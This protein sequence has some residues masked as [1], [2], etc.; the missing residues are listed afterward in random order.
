MASSHSASVGLASRTKVVKM[1]DERSHDALE[2]RV[3]AF[4][5]APDHGLSNAPL[6]EFAHVYSRSVPERRFQGFST[7]LTGTCC[8]TCDSPPTIA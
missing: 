1:S 7:R 3:V 8:S 6:I 2:S 4:G 5:Q